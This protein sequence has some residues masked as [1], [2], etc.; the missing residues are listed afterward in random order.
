MIR[1]SNDVD[2]TDIINGLGTTCSRDAMTDDTLLLEEITNYSENLL[3]TYTHIQELLS[4]WM[5]LVILEHLR[6]KRYSKEKWWAL[7]NYEGSLERYTKLYY[8]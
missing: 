7:R 6:G 8:L 4:R 1:Y 5:H 3:Y 2:L